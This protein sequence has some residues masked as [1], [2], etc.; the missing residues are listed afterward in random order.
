MRRL[1][2]R[3]SR[4]P[5]GLPGPCLRG[6]ES[7]GTALTCYT[8]RL[9]RSVSLFPALMRSSLIA[10]A[11]VSFDAMISLR[12]GRRGGQDIFAWDASLLSQASSR[13]V[14]RFHPMAWHCFR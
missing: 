9:A 5:G 13:T 12:H 7:A 2:E 11:V 10:G 14:E 3:I 8:N 1:A 6:L 4:P